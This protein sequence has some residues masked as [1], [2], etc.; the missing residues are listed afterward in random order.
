[1]KTDLIFLLNEK[2]RPRNLLPRV[3]NKQ[4]R[5]ASKQTSMLMLLSCLVAVT[6][7]GRTSGA[8]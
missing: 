1:M 8:A 3:Q 6:T 2:R 4:N 7:G 5:H